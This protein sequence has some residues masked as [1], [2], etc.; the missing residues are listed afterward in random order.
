MLYMK[1]AASHEMPSRDRKESTPKTCKKHLGHLLALKEITA[2][3]EHSLP[4][5][6]KLKRCGLTHA[7]DVKH[8]FKLLG[9]L[10]NQCRSHRTERSH[11]A[12]VFDM[13]THK[14]TSRLE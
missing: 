5:L 13:Y 8:V 6:R 11:A 7:V 1:R 14:S 9:G 4:N 3:K 12:S 10:P 2:G